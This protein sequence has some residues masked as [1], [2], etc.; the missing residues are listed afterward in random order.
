[1]LPTTLCAPELACA[2]L[3]FIFGKMISCL[4][5][6]CLMWKMRIARRREKMWVSKTDVYEDVNGI[7]VR[8]KEEL[9]ESQRKELAK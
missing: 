3:V 1:M 6:G 8:Y 4:S 9:M 7:V 2:D 5:I